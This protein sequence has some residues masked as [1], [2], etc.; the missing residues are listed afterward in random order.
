MAPAAPPRVDVSMM[1][2]K[3]YA[4][5]V[6]R[7]LHELEWDEADAGGTA[8][9]HWFDAPISRAHFARVAPEQAINRFYG[10][11]R[12]CRKVC[13]A[14]QLRWAEALYGAGHTVS[15]Q[16]W[17]LPAELA[18]FEAAVPA[19]GGAFIL[20]P[21][22]G[23][24]GDGIVLVR[25]PDAVRAARSLSRRQRCVAQIY[26]DRPL[27]SA[28]PAS[29]GH[30]F[31]LRMYALLMCAH[32]FEAYVCTRALARVAARPYAPVEAG[33]REHAACAG[34][35]SSEARRS[36]VAQ[37]ERGGELARLD[38]YIHLTNS[39][40]AMPLT[41]LSNKLGWS[42]RADGASGVG[43]DAGVVWA[44][45][46]DVVHV[47]VRSIC[48]LASELYEQALPSHTHGPRCC[49]QVLGVDVLIDADSKPWLIELNHSPSM[50]LDGGDED[51][52]T[53]KVGVVKAAMLLSR[54]A[55]GADDPAVAGICAAHGLEPLHAT[56]QPAARPRA[57]GRHLD[58]S[59]DVLQHLRALFD[60][61]AEPRRAASAGAS[62][63]DQPV[64]G[65]GVLPVVFAAVA[66][67][68]GL[69][70]AR[71]AAERSARGALGRLDDIGTGWHTPSLPRP[72]GLPFHGLI[73]AT[74]SLA[75]ALADELDALRRAVD[76]GGEQDHSHQAA[77]A[78]QGLTQLGA[79]ADVLIAAMLKASVAHPAD[80]GPLPDRRASCVAKGRRASASA[81]VGAPGALAIGLSAR[82]R[83]VYRAHSESS[84][85]G[86]QLASACEMRPS[87]D[88]P[89]KDDQA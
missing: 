83:R 36:D 31:D 13:L 87:Q 68:T 79:R 62:G 12:L 35:A 20:K 26:V 2:A 19:L 63:F 67:R 41:G 54:T 27:L 71:D 8:A 38:P 17:C 22:A 84:I 21:D 28:A 78:A 74:L 10:M 9:L 46:R 65:R 51:E 50:A 53:T 76:G 3:Y 69:A 70:G 48:A 59:P 25:A 88:G 33:R 23:C 44:S 34:T 86:T 30:K 1:S 56:S 85:P 61:L 52:V 29:A 60:A 32:P 11:V 18:A 47:G 55:S 37:G 6:R 75:E 16:T 15:P 42:A 49:F 64:G 73:R 5:A 40:L 39:S 45:I 77:S 89:S 81:D 57:A 7:A 4:A 72:R 43:V 24:Q 82:G 80:R 66:E 14:H 58:A